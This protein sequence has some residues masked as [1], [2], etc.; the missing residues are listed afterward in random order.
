VQVRDALAS[1]GL[2]LDAGVILVSVR[3]D[4][5]LMAEHI[6]AV[7]PHF[8]LVAGSPLADLHVEV[9]L[10]KGLRRWVHP[11]AVLWCDGQQHFHPFPADTALPLL[12]WGINGLVAEQMHHLL[13][14][15][16]GCLERDGLGLLLPA[17]PGSGKSTLSAALAHRGW[18][19]LSDEFGVCDPATGLLHAMLKPVALKNESINIIRR[20]APEAII[21]PEFP[22]T[23]KGTVAH[24]AAPADAVARRGQAATP[25]VVILPK[26]VA[27]SPTRIQP[28][29]DEE[30][31]QALAFNAFN[32]EV[33]GA[34]GFQAVLALVRRCG[35]WQ[36]EYS[37]LHD[38]VARL[39]AM[40]SDGSLMRPPP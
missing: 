18:R 33:L 32:Y 7:Y 34:T 25:S 40:W 1:E 35:G 38:A 6:R 26:W 36:M 17:I 19:L 16:A 12:E 30:L 14:L 39:D 29:A 24:V 37:D 4:V 2:V 3:S 8:A 10:A 15:H 13:L 31:F 22:K 21:G 20:F 9:L 5:P 28:V 11:Q 27:G 23:R